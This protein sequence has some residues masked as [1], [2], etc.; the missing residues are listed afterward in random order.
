MELHASVDSSRRCSKHALAQLQ[1]L[2]P[3]L[4]SSRK[5]LS[6]GVFRFV[7]R[8]RVLRLEPKL[9]A[10]GAHELGRPNDIYTICDI[11]F[12]TSHG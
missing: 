6:N 2:I 1:H 12:P 3:K 7:R 8:Q 10:P 4:E 5:M 9:A 11:V